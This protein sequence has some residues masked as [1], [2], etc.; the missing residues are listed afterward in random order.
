MLFSLVALIVSCLA[1]FPEL[2]P[3]TWQ[4][5]MLSFLVY[6]V[7][8]L[9]VYGYESFRM[10]KDL[11]EI[12]DD[13]SVLFLLMNYLSENDC[14]PGDLTFERIASSELEELE[15]MLGNEKD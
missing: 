13:E 12:A 15:E 2:R 10:K 3:T 1:L 9:A 6:T 14:L 8:P 7:V 4:G 11:R 5:R